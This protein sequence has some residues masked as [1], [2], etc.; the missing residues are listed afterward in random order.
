M[1]R[2]S[3]RD[4]I[5]RKFN[6][7]TLLTKA[8]NKID[9]GYGSG[10]PCDACGDTIYHAQAQYELS[11][12]DVRR[13]LRLHFGCAGLWEALRLQRGLDPAF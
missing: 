4:V 12:P 8:P 1:D 13:V 5:L 9:T 7:G 3:L 10:A 11:Y 6:D 2:V